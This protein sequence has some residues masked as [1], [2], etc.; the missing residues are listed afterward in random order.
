MDYDMF[1]KKKSTVP[2][3]V[4]SNEYIHEIKTL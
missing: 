3:L 2:I 1:N 4:M